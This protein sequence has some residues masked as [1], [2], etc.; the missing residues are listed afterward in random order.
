MRTDGKLWCCV[1][2]YLSNIRCHSMLFIGVDA[3][4][5]ST[6]VFNLRT[7]ITKYWY[8]T[9]NAH[10]RPTCEGSHSQLIGIVRREPLIKVGVKF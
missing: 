10:L 1:S 9:K 8:S 3:D 5:R 4:V 7:L 2:N 6:F